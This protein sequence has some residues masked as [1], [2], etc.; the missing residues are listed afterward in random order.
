MIKGGDGLPSIV[1]GNPNKSFLMEVVRGYNA[2]IKMPPKG[3]KLGENQIELIHADKKKV[4]R[5]GQ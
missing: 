2:D 3:E 1:P 5:P 4:Y